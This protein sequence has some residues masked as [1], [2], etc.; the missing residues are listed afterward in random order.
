MAKIIVRIPVIDT[1]QNENCRPFVDILKDRKNVEFVELLPYHSLGEQK[2]RELGVKVPS[3][4]S[5]TEKSLAQMKEL[6][7]RNHIPVKVSGKFKK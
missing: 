1:I 5:P 7:E 6:L 3:Y 2:Y 4:K